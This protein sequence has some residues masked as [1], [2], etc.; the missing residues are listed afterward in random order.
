MSNFIKSLT[1][2][3]LSLYALLGLVNTPYDSPI[4]ICNGGDP[5]LVETQDG[6][7]YTYTTGGGIDIIKTRSI[8]K[9]DAI[10]KK[11]VFGQGSVAQKEIYGR[12]KFTKSATD[13][14]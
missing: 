1:T 7:Y 9:I 10:D 5:F 14:I 11:T 4:D 6:C 13:G 3:I 2:V 12:L 8:D